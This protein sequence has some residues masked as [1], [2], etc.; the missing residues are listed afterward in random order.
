MSSKQ[1]EEPSS[2]TAGKAFRAHFGKYVAHAEALGMTTGAAEALIGIDAALFA[3][4]RR[5]LKGEMVHS[6][7]T[8]LG[9]DI[10]PTEFEA[11]TALSRLKWGVYGMSRTDVAVG[12][13]AEEM[14]IDPSRASRLVAS[15]VAKG[16][17]RRDVAQD[18][19]RKTVLKLTPASLA[20][21]DAVMALKWHLLFA[22]FRDWSDSDI[23][24]FERLFSRYLVTM[25]ALIARAGNNGAEGDRLAEA[26]RQA[27]KSE[28]ASR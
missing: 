4:R 12:D 5:M 10:E 16:Y 23:A 6:I 19:A 9:L 3:W 14:A 8:D 24:D 13:I 21:F 26:I 22:A 18:D 15:L 2:R 25:D 20:L 28:L 27:V 17:V 7:L 1:V 11:L